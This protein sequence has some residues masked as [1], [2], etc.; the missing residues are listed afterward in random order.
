ME[1]RKI[2]KIMGERYYLIDTENVGDRWIEF[3]P[4]LQEEEQLVVFYTQ[5]HSKLLE[6]TF[7]KQRYNKQ[8]DWVECFVGSNALDY[9]LMGVLSYLV[10][11]NPTASYAIY[12][13]DKD[14]KNIIEFWNRRNVFVE[15]IG[16]EIVCTKSKKK[17]KKKKQKQSEEIVEQ[18]LQPEETL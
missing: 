11:N 18:L 7:L 1:S 15:K 2:R 16:F 6:E 4:Q 13:N 8:I 9:Q 3:I 5:N 12:S 14:Y 17:K 10:A